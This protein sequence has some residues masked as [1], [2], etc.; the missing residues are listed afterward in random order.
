MQGKTGI[1]EQSSHVEDQ[2]DVLIA[3]S[4]CNNGNA[5]PTTCQLL[6]YALLY[7]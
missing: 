1:T 3:A 7:Y 4:A 5:Y 6:L 2:Q